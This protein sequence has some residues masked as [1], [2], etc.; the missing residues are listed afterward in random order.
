MNWEHLSIFSPRHLIS[1]TSIQGIKTERYLWFVSLLC[2]PVFGF[3]LWGHLGGTQRSFVPCRDHVNMT[4][5]LLRCTIRQKVLVS[6]W[7]CR[8]FCYISH[9]RVF[10]A[11]VYRARPGSTAGTVSAR[12]YII[13][14]IYKVYSYFSVLGCIDWLACYWVS[15]QPADVRLWFEHQLHH[16]S[17]AHISYFMWFHFRSTTNRAG[18]FYMLKFH[19]QPYPSRYQDS[20][21]RAL[22]MNY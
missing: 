10:C 16:L 22:F 14:E 21:Y 9:P 19:S 5:P 7:N 8:F 11:S 20:I 6:T 15:Q 17:H 4:R 18:M 3:P 13:T 1:H 2:S 12:H